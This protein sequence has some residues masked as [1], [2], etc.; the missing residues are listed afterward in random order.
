MKKYNSYQEFNACKSQCRACPI[1]L[2]YDK[3]V[4]SD[5]NTLNPK[6]VICGEAPGSDE[7]EQGKPFVGKA[8]KLLR[9]TIKEFGF[10]N[11]NC[12]IT[13][14][15]PCRPKDNKF[16]EDN[17]LVKNCKNTW[18]KEELLLTNPDVLLLIGAKPLKFLLGLEGITK[19]RGKWIKRKLNGKIIQIMPTYHSSYV[20]RKK[21]MAE[22]KQI[23]EDFRDDIAKVAAICGFESI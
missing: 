13:N 5:G 2:I 3:V 22:G 18:L 6:V 11:E 16:P 20:L 12:L 19:L 15:I 7:V 1:G 21:F 8:G 4:C 17:S 10:T 9:S 23:L 14:T